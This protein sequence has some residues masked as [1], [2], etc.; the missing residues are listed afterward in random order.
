ML[1]A[2]RIYQWPA[3]AGHPKRRFFAPRIERSAFRPC[4]IKAICVVVLLALWVLCGAGLGRAD[5]Q[6]N[7]LLN[8]DLTKGSGNSPDNWRTAAW[9]NGPEFTTYR[10][11]RLPGAP[12]ELEVS[13]T[14]ANDAYWAQ[15]V[16]LAPG[17]Y[18]FTA[19]VRAEAIPQNSSG[20]N[21]SILEDG[22]TS[23]H[24]R[25]TSDWQTIGFYLKVGDSGAEVAL[26]CRL[27]GFAS[28]NTGKAFCRDLRAVK[29]DA[30]PANAEAAFKYDLDVIRHPAGMP[31]AAAKTS[32]V[33]GSVIPI[34]LELL[35]A[36]VVI[37]FVAWRQFH[38][39]VPTTTTIRKFAD[40]LR[41]LAP[42]AAPVTAEQ[43]PNRRIEVALFLVTFVSF[44]Y[45]YQAS[46]HGT[47][48]RFD[49]MRAIVERHT[50]WVDGYCGY[51]T[52]D[53]VSVGPSAGSHLYSVKAPGGAFTGL[54]AWIFFSNVLSPLES[55]N[56]A[57]YWAFTTYLTIIFSTG[58]LVAMLCV[59]MHRFALFVGA[60]PGRALTLALI[61]GFATILFPYATEMTGE[62]IAAA[63]AF[64]SFYLLATDRLRPDAGRT[65]TAGLLAGWAVLCDFPAFLIAGPLAVYALFK[66]GRRVLPFAAG[67]GGV[68]L[69]LFIHNKIAF[70]N[71]FFLSY[72][73]YKLSV[74]SQFPE[75]AVGFVGLTYPRLH[76]LWKILIDPERGLLFCNPVMI[77]VI[78]AL[79]FFVARR[80]YR[81]EF[82]VAIIAIV[83]FILFN[84][85]FGESIVSWGGG[86]ATGPRQIVAA[87]PFMVFALA[88]L[89]SGW[90]YVLAPLAL[91]SA[92][93]MLMATAVEPHLPYEY[94]NPLR[95]FVWPAYLRGDLAYNRST[96]FGGPP[97]AGD[98]VAFNLGKLVGLPGAVQLLPLA[99]L[100]IAAAE[101]FL[102][103]LAPENDSSRHT[104]KAVAA[105]LVIGALFV[106]PIAGV[107]LAR[108]ALRR[109][110][111][112]LGRYYE[113]L[114]PEGFPPHI[115]RVDRTIDFPSIEELGALPYPSFVVWT[116]RILAPSTG[117]YHF[118]IDVDDAG[119]LKI[120]GQSVIDDPGEVSKYHDSGGMYLTA[121]THSIEVGERN[122]VGGSSIRLL[123]QP[124][125]GDEQVVPDRVLVPH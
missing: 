61:L 92:F 90:D 86:T 81:A 37:G 105:A 65:M 77:L 88:F 100:W 55:H 70:G 31:Q 110:H 16:H 35:I 95:A 112:L 28:L 36:A 47:G 116:G 57:V 9:K 33:P 108:A 17:W 66:L 60:P 46:D 12:S 18:H 68:A 91:V 4:A 79:I 76:L 119:W 56:E 39:R 5:V 103:A 83:G 2:A 7:V 93:L 34:V 122:L 94:H 42:K 26:A 101:Y 106:P 118:A 109:E 89:P 49:L 71:P 84:A 14:K 1:T 102:R 15:T 13:S 114:R 52:A 111:G 30:P 62:P 20:A 63:C 121:G 115:Q 75:Q 107:P 22:I 6:D 24:L 54:P 19:S 23:P 59:V 125:G 10:W 32:L 64:T 72:E 25:G 98:S 69:I 85:S 11:H 51:N 58:L 45:F 99:A 48:A 82:A 74:N 96:Y 44:A 53:I 67:A 73:A 117:L 97:I 38:G 87:I 3:R 123:W 43:R 78:P 104:L 113:G 21:I 41:Q 120:D 124:P 50:L 27:G 40:A 80:Q 8:G 29:I